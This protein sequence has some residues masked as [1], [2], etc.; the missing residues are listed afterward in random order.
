MSVAS[1]LSFLAC[2]AIATAIVYASLGRRG[3]RG[4]IAA[5]AGVAALLLIAGFGGGWSVHAIQ[6]TA[7]DHGRIAA[8]N[9]A[10]LEARFQGSLNMNV[11]DTLGLI[12]CSF[13]DW[14][15][16]DG[17]EGAEI[18]NEATY[19]YLRLEFAEDR[20]V[21]ALGV[22]RTEQIGVLRGLIQSRIRLGDWK[23][24][25]LTEPSR[26]VEAYVARTRI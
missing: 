14:A 20:L 15:G 22:G 6:P 13:G 10:G 21:G 4:R 25:L 2:V 23:E 17:G 5:S 26:F 24:K 19:K 11:L 7:V 3:A 12:S 9:M 1:A 8:L 16:V 18:L